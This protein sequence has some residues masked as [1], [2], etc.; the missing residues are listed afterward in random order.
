MIFLACGFEQLAAQT[1]LPQTAD[2][3]QTIIASV[4]KPPALAP[5]ANAETAGE[6]AMNTLM[7]QF[8]QTLGGYLPQ[9]VG[10]LSRFSSWVGCWRR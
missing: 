5:V 4:E 9:V 8:E 3:T 2:T 7:T 6:S 1:T 10:A